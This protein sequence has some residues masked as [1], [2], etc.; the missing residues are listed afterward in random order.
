MTRP[1]RSAGRDS[2]CALLAREQ[3]PLGRDHVLGAQ[4]SRVRLRRLLGG[5]TRAEA[6]RSVAQ[7]DED[8]AAVVAPAMNPAGHAHPLADLGG[9][10]VPPPTGCDSGS[11]AATSRPA[12]PSRPH[13]SLGKRHRLVGA[14]RAL[15]VAGLH[16]LDLDHASDDH[17]RAGADAVG[18]GRADLQR[19]SR[20]LDLC[21]QPPLAQALGERE[22]RAPSRGA[23]PPITRRCPAARRR[24]GPARSVPRRPAQPTPGVGGPSALPPMVMAPAAA[25]GRSAPRASPTRRARTPCRV[26]RDRGRA[27]SRPRT[28]ARRRQ[29]ERTSAKC[30]ASSALR[31]SSSRGTARWRRARPGRVESNARSEFLVEPRAHVVGELGLV[32]AR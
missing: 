27:W 24:A 18:I 22:R 26:D 13:R 21:A 6:G 12:P 32:P 4:T 1:R 14:G 5:G 25:E 31:R 30:S 28:R 15:L 17:G 9:A 16:V 29:A 23:R 11:G 19:A 7:I 3:L 10:E 8:Q 2:R 20:L